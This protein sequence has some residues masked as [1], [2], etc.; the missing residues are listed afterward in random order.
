MWG[1]VIQVPSYQE[2]AGGK[3]KRNI[4]VRPVRRR[5]Q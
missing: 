3:V 2:T 4:N 1:D 5:F